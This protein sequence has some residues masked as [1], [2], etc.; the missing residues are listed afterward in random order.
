MTADTDLTLTLINVRSIQVVAQVR[1]FN[2]DRELSDAQKEFEAELNLRKTMENGPF[3]G[4]GG[5][6]AAPEPVV[7]AVPGEALRA[8]KPKP[9][10]F[11]P[12]KPAK[13][14]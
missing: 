7:E 10:K 12:K 4:M 13:R 9:S 11:V 2:L 8:A 3:G 1:Q 14:K 6:I 5:A